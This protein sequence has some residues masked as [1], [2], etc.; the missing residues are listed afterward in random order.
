MRFLTT[1]LCFLC[2]FYQG[3]IAPIASAQTGSPTN[4]GS[5]S[6]PSSDPA[7]PTYM[8]YAT[9]DSDKMKEHVKS[10]NS[11]MYQKTQDAGLDCPA[12]RANPLKNE[13]GDLVRGGKFDKSGAEGLET[14]GLIIENITLIAAVFF[15]AEFVTSCTNLDTVMAALAGLLF[16]IMEIVNWNAY[17]EASDKQANYYDSESADLLDEQIKSFERAKKDTDK[18][19]EAANKRAQVA[20]SF[21]TG[22]AVVAIITII[23]AIL[24]KIWEIVY[25]PDCY[26]VPPQLKDGNSI[27]KITKKY[28]FFN[29]IID[30]IF[31][32]ANA[33][34]HSD[35]Q[36]V[37]AS[38][39][40]L[41][42]S[43]T[44][45]FKKSCNVRN[46]KSFKNKK[47]ELL[48]NKYE[49]LKKSP[50]YS[51]KIKRLE[52]KFVANNLE[53]RSISETLSL[54]LGEVFP[55][56]HA[57][58][59]QAWVQGLGLGV[60]AIVILLGLSTG[61][62]KVWE[63]LGKNGITRFVV[64]VIISA[65][66]FIVYSLVEEAAK[67]YEDQ[68]EEYQKI[69]DKLNGKKIQL[70]ITAAENQAKH[71]GPGPNGDVN[72]T[73]NIQG[74]PGIQVDQN[75]AGLGTLGANNCMNLDITE[76]ADGDEDSDPSGEIVTKSCPCKT[77]SVV[78]S[79]GELTKH[80]SPETG[81]V[82]TALEDG[83]GALANGSFGATEQGSLLAVT[84]ANNSA[85]RQAL[86]DSIELYKQKREKLGLP[87][88]DFDAEVKK[89]IEQAKAITLK[90]INGLSAS[91]RQSLGDSMGVKIPGNIQKNFKTVA[92]SSFKGLTGRKKGRKKNKKNK[93]KLKRRKKVEPGL[94]GSQEKL[95]YAD[96]LKGSGIKE[97]DINTDPG[98]PIWD[99]IHYRYRKSAYPVFLE[100]EKKP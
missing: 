9:V 57:M 63:N 30:L 22:I 66:A 89:G 85:V 92:L 83:G 31:P 62:A 91:Q 37:L 29:K 5:S 2:V 27:A 60:A 42:D 87:D 84:G 4:L 44:P 94:A 35:L 67:K 53:E 72:Q 32:S 95:N 25:D 19:A 34:F 88:I 12:P 3:L 46:Q 58:D 64:Y 20:M 77:C 8:E 69:I 36:S 14:A 15:F 23:N 100:R 93:L 76:P 49:E 54:V 55:K 74:G 70:A 6:T 73:Q 28:P 1:W 41:I 78:V 61:L 99:I 68:S 59:Q 43:A 86:K 26:Y 21:G 33:S 81:A 65:L 71:S 10:Q 17:K 50:K 98:V 7:C 24:Y 40:K 39:K 45:S 11:Q 51:K 13:K 38:P 16:V 48:K 90:G 56:A 82:L 75:L 96:A 79:P 52:K 18:A 80:I 97:S 47:V